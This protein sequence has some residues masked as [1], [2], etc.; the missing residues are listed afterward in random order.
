MLPQ[1]H[2]AHHRFLWTSLK[3]SSFLVDSECA[4]WG[5]KVQQSKKQ[6]IRLI[7]FSEISEELETITA[8]FFSVITIRANTFLKTSQLFGLVVASCATAFLWVIWSMS[9]KQQ[10]VSWHAHRALALYG[11]NLL[12]PA[13]KN[14]GSEMGLHLRWPNYTMYDLLKHWD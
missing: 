5:V 12:T 7:K 6:C 1:S 4:K 10:L 11:I 9:H 13:Q 14:I 3:V 8:Q 2:V